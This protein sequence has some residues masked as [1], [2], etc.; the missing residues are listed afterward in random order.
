MHIQF[1]IQC[2]THCRPSTNTGS[3]SLIKERIYIAYQSKNLIANFRNQ[4]CK[5]SRIKRDMYCPYKLQKQAASEMTG[6]KDLTSVSPLSIF[7]LCFILIVALF[8]QFTCPFHFVRNMAA[9]KSQATSPCFATTGAL[10]QIKTSDSNWSL[11]S[12]THQL[13]EGKQDGTVTSAWVLCSSPETSE[14]N[15]GHD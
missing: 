9:S 11:Q 7:A 5:S 4:Q 12:W 3:L 6:T 2:I 8:M 15:L 14:R 10:N 13:K 1:I